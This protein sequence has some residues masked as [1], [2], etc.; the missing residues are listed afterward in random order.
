M[1]DIAFEI[2]DPSGNRTGVVSF[3]TPDVTANLGGNICQMVL[4]EHHRD[5]GDHLLKITISPVAAPI[6]PGPWKLD[7]IGRTLNSDQNLVD[8]WVERHGSRPVYFRKDEQHVTLSIPGT[9]DTVITVGACDASTPVRVSAFSS[10][11]RTRQGNAK[12]DLCA[13]GHGILAAHSNQADT[14][15]VVSKPGTSMA[16][17]H[18][19][20]ALAL[21][22]SHRHKA[23]GKTQLNANQLQAL[24]KNNLQFFNPRHHPGTGF[25]VL[26]VE[27][28]FNAVDA[29]P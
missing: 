7:V 22:M 13:P 10:Y 19:T 28:F 8:V 3:D 29:K 25:G 5:N 1:D 15:A 2:E 6:Q 26:D 12:P 21:A 27:A 20:G 11:G 24:L 9:A 16:A 18:V 14:A 23:S 4:T 17:P